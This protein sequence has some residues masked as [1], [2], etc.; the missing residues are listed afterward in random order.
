MRL[1]MTTTV[2]DRHGDRQGCDGVSQA[3]LRRGKLAMPVGR[4]RGAIGTTAGG[5]S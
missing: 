4:S 2:G 1:A 5:D 3:A